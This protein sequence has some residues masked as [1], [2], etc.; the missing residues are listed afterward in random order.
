MLLPS[1]AGAPATFTPAP[2][3]PVTLPV[4][5]APTF[6]YNHSII[7]SRLNTQWENP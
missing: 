5:V 1:P 4:A 3:S 7:A 2:A 6:H